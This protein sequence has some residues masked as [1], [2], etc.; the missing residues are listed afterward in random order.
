MTFITIKFHETLMS[1]FKGVVLTKKK[2][3]TGGQT[4]HIYFDDNANTYILYLQ[5]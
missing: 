5:K 3:K 4:K 1:G 2:N